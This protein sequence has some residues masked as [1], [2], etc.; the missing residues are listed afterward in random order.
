MTKFLTRMSGI[1]CISYH[2]DT[3]HKSNDAFDPNDEVIK[4][5]SL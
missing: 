2:K 1:E 5:F 4:A 3:N